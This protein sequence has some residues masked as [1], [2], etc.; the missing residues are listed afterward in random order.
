MGPVSAERVSELFRGIYTRLHA[1]KSRGEHASA[2]A[3]A[4]LQ[5][6]ERSGPLT[7]SEAAAHFHRAQSAVSEMVERLER[8]GLVERMRD[9]RDRRRA[10][11]WLTP[12]G[13]ALLRRQ[14][15]VLSQ[16]LLDRALA[17]MPARDRRQL[18]DGMS[19]LVRAAD[20]LEKERP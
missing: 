4:V 12:R 15:Q 1:R 18:V 13:F 8:R 17:A 11:V 10:L 19:A 3:T 5:H 2:E 20:S 14:E 9:A 6:L 16:A 7:I